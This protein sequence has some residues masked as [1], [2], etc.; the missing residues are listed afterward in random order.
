MVMYLM[1]IAMV[2]FNACM[3][4]FE[5]ENYFESRFKKWNPRFWYKRESW[6]HARKLGGYKL[7]AWHMSKSLMLLC[8]AAAVIAAKCAP[9]GGSWWVILI[10]IGIIWNGGFWLFYHKLFGIR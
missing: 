10:N 8:F 6:K 5:N 2:F 1:V 9:P 3:D 4:A 7:D